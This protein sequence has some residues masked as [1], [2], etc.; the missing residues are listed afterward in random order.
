MREPTG[1]GRVVGGHF[2]HR[3]FG[4]TG[5]LGPEGVVWTSYDNAQETAGLR[6]AFMGRQFEADMQSE[7]WGMVPLPDTFLRECTSPAGSALL[8]TSAMFRLVDFNTSHEFYGYDGY[9]HLLSDQ[10]PSA[11][12][13]PTSLFILVCPHFFGPYVLQACLARFCSASP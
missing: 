6:G 2:V 8:G 5:E 7:K 12:L 4:Y 1:A 10:P 11:Q 13:Y 3:G 9:R